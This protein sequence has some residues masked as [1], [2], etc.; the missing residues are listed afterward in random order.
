[1]STD[2]NEEQ[3]I[4]QIRKLAGQLGE[5]MDSEPVDP[6]D[7]ESYDFQVM[8]GLARATV[9]ITDFDPE[10]LYKLLGYCIIGLGLEINPRISAL[11]DALRN[12]VNDQLDE[13]LESEKG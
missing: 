8:T 13:L 4:L 1:M 9:D 3:L 2:K 7:A 6:S 5:L 12:E 11:M 10:K